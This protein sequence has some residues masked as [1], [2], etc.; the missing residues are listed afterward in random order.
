MCISTGFY[1]CHGS[2]PNSILFIVALVWSFVLYIP[3]HILINPCVQAVCFFFRVSTPTV[4]PLDVNRVLSYKS[5]RI[6]L[7]HCIAASREVHYIQLYHSE[8]VSVYNFLLVLLLSLCINSCRP[9][10][11]TWDFSSSSF[12]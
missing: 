5:L 10:Q 11:F 9:F 8:S 2:R 4:L 1:M 3:N 12:L 6:V 7:D